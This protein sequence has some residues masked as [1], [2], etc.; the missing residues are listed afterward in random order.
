METEK[1]DSINEKT[2]NN[3]EQDKNP[4]HLAENFSINDWVQELDGTPIEN[5]EESA[6]NTL[7]KEESEHES[8]AEIVNSDTSHIN[9]SSIN[10]L[11]IDT[12]N[13]VKH[14]TK[15]HLI[16]GEKGGVGK[17]FVSRSL[18]E[19]CASINHKI[20]IVDADKS[21]EDIAKIYNNVQSAFFSDDD[22]QAKEADQIFD[23]AF[24]E[25]VVVNLPAQVYSKVTD[26][27]KKNDL[28]EVGKEHQITFIKWFVCIGS[29]DSVNFFLQSL[30]D[31]GDRMTHVFVR[32]FG[33]CDDWNYIDQMSEFLAAKDTYTFTEMNFPKFPFWERNIIDRLGTTFEDGISHPDLK[34]VSKQRVKNFLKKAYVEFAQTG[35]I[36]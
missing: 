26:W 10:T 3:M 5:P 20:I 16:D 4:N 24:T 34:V 1:E 22:K 31:L 6:D 35:L 17:S 7:N 9:K 14:P 28:T 29:V 25:S 21:N 15:I 30:K 19:Y 2:S 8:Q 23:L 32:N 12:N 36:E 27:I 13:L 33:L 11:T 18:I